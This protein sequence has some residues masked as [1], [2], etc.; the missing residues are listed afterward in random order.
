MNGRAFTLL[1]IVDGLLLTALAGCGGG[2]GGGYGSMGMGTPAPTASFSQPAAAGHHQFRSGPDPHLDVGLRDLLH[3]N[4]LERGRRR[5]HG[6]PNE[7][8][9]PDGRPD[10]GRNLYL[11][12]ELHR[13]RRDQ[14]GIRER[15]RHAQPSRRPGADR[16]RSRWSDRRSI[17]STAT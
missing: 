10:R 3:R 2:G 4:D 7:Q 15:D 9:Q 1:G 17:R 16:L 8:R 13:D 5:I 14:I 6:N 11:Y 12:A